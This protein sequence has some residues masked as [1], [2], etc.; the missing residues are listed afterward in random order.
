[1]KNA[2]VRDFTAQ[3]VH[4]LRIDFVPKIARCLEM[5]TDEEIWWRPNENS[6]SVGNLILHLCGNV[7]QWIVS[8]VGRQPDRR[9][10]DLEFS[11][12]EA[13]PAK[14]LIQQLK[15]TVDEAAAVIESLDEPRLMEKRRIQIY[16]VTALQAV[17]HVVEHFSCHTGQILY[18][19]KMLKDRDLGFYAE[20]D[21]KKTV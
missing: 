2:L 7:R 8:G 10:R 21:R 4:H 5:L 14:E 19:T 6:N 9:R 16:D 11:T 18:V 15:A 1:M 3:A 20:L 17:F 12:R 13:R